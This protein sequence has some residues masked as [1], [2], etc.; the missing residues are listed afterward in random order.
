MLI[1]INFWF[2]LEAVWSYSASGTSLSRKKYAQP[3]TPSPRAGRGRNIGATRRPAR[4][5]GYKPGVGDYETPPVEH[6]ELPLMAV[7]HEY[8]RSKR[9]CATVREMKEGPSGSAI[10]S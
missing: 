9:R 4:H 6:H 2:G 3:A 7:C 8:R 10:R 1:C 5:M